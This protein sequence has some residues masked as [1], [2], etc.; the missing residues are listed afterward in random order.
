MGR[1][2]RRHFQTTRKILVQS[3]TNVGRETVI[4]IVV[5]HPNSV[6]KAGVT[7]RV[8]FVPAT[9]TEGEGEGEAAETQATAPSAA[10]LYASI[11]LSS[12][13]P[14]PPPSTSGATCDV[15]SL[16]ITTSP[17]QHALSAAHQV[18][19]AHSHPPSS[20]DRSRMGLRTLQSQG[21]DPDARRGLGL[22]GEGVPFPLKAEAKHDTRGIGAAAQI[23]V[24]KSSKPAAPVTK[25][26]RAKSAAEER[27]RAAWLQAEL[28]S[29]VDVERYL[30][31]DDGHV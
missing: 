3:C 20:L 24:D 22:Y 5:R 9:R 12:R 25:Q 2:R 14:E 4:G 28:Y 15:C 18:S 21:W 16:T 26:Q 27:Q 23:P 13:E 1:R 11:V 30:R 6:V 8:E 29:R 7:R 10:D 19:L 31:G 17:R